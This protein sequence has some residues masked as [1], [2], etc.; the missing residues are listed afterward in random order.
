MTKLP[1]RP[2][3]IYHH[4]TSQENKTSIFWGVAWA[5]G[6]L[7]L[8]K[9]PTCN[10][11]S[12]PLAWDHHCLALLLLAAEIIS[13]LHV[14]WACTPQLLSALY[15]L[16]WGVFLFFF[17]N[18]SVQTVVQTN[19]GR[20]SGRGTQAPVIFKVVQV[21][22]MCSKFENHYTQKMIII[23]DWSLH[24]SLSH[25]IRP[26]LSSFNQHRSHLESL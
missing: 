16:T 6:Y 18:F 9:T 1:Y 15:R 12:E 20:I 21:I 3:N 7:N 23:R 2:D 5:S 8:L 22:S 10:K 4:T 25:G 19:H 26:H 11:V 14:L 24:I 13:N 17:F